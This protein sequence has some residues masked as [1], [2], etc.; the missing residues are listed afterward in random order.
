MNLRSPYPYCLLRHGIINSYPS[1]GRN[2]ST[3]VAIIGAGISG[4]LV[5]RQLQQAGFSTVLLDRRHAGMGSTAAST[6]LLQYEI[7]TPLVRLTELVGEEHAARSY[8]LCREAIYKFGEICRELNDPTIFTPSPSFQFASHK[9]DIKP[10]EKEFLR[11][12]EL[13]FDIEWLSA[14][15]VKKTFGFSRAAG[16][17]SADGAST[18]SYKVTHLI[19]GELIKGGGKVYDNTEVISIHPY[20]RGVQLQTSTGG[21]VKAKRLVIACGYE[22]QRYIPFKVQNLHSTYAIASETYH[23]NEFWYRNALIWETARPYLY[24]STTSDNRIVMGGKDIPMTGPR[25]RDQLLPVKTKALEKSFGELFPKIAWK[26]DFQWTGNFAS[27]KDG[28]PYIGAI[29][30]M[31]HTYFALGFGGNGITFSVIA[32]EIIR[33]LLQGKANPDAAIF[34]FD[35]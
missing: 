31:Q 33:D 26:T 1:L 21:V 11:R 27:T 34:R 9:K 10:L 23:N 15:Q 24:L 3:D 18:N 16:I 20:K 28:L 19:L 22:S 25:R 12:S 5:A 6:N 29:R 13:G 8:I 4:A 2:I 14:Q 32:A 17:L 7:D 30:Q 35:R